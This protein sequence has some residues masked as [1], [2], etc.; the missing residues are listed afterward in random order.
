MNVVPAGDVH[1]PEVP[2][3][4]ALIKAWP[5]IAGLEF[6][7]AFAHEGPPLAVGAEERRLAR[8]MPAARRSDFLTG[9][10][11]LHRA[12][13]KAGLAAPDV[14][15]DGPRP[16]L[17]A[18]VSASLS[19]SGGTAVAV[20]G[21]AG[22]F[23]TLGVDLELAGPPPS[24]AHLV[25]HQEEAILLASAGRRPLLTLFSAK[26]AAFKAFSPLA[27]ARLPGLRAVRLRPFADGYLARTGCLDLAVRVYVRPLPH[28]VLTCAVPY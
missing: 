15:F 11:A 22:R 14:L 21:P 12:L 23:R 5:R 17:P 3:P 24:A 6:A 27:G 13:R 28:G 8:S 19:H 4:R 25:L 7:S 2:F 10:S 16:R 20:A 26:E 1:T 18:G 9:R